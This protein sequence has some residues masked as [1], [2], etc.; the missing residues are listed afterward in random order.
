MLDGWHVFLI[1]LVAY[2]VFESIIHID[3]LVK[4]DLFDM[5]SAIKIDTGPPK[6][7]EHTHLLTQPSGQSSFQYPILD[8]TQKLALDSTTP[9]YLK[10]EHNLAIC[11]LIYLLTVFSPSMCLTIR[12]MVKRPCHTGW[13][14]ENVPCD[15]P[16]KTNCATSTRTNKTK[17]KTDPC[18]AT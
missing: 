12:T 4:I 9:S 1:C 10:R 16:D 6:E 11:R 15:N 5:F 2:A 8:R 14:Y 18:P 7:K 17:S 3:N 13:E